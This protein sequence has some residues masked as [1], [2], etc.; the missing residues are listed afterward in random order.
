M[1]NNVIDT[2]GLDVVW[3]PPNKRKL[4]IKEIRTKLRKIDA[5]DDDIDDALDALIELA[6]DKGE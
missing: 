4:A 5:T 6:Q 2:A 3:T 1:S